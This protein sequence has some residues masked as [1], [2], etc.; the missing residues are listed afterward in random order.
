M[1]GGLIYGLRLRRKLDGCIISCHHCH[2]LGA[3]CKG[4][5]GLKTHS[6]LLVRCLRHRLKPQ[7]GLTLRQLPALELNREV[8]ET[9]QT[10]RGRRTRHQVFIL[11]MCM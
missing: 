7:L 1:M 9:V 11:S 6:Y 3:C 8:F 2:L 5:C 10:I 4:N